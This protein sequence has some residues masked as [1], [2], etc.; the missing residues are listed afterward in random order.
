MIETFDDL[1]EMARSE[2]V[3]VKLLTVLVRAEPVM[4][5]DSDGNE[6]PIEGEGMLTPLMVKSHAVE[7]TPGFEFLRA[8]ADAGKKDWTFMMIGVLP[9]QPGQPPADDLVD[10]QLKNMARAI[11]AGSGLDRYL[12]FDRNGI[13][14]QIGYPEQPE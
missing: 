1:L 2:P 10:E 12:F 7:D 9:G 6:V 8:D 3:P 5:T 14:V 4:Q 11:H 13:P